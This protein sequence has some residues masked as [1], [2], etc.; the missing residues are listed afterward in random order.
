MHLICLTINVNYS[1]EYTKARYF[2]FR[3]TYI[4]FFPLSQ[5]FV[6]FTGESTQHGGIHVVDKVSGT[7]VV[8]DGV[9][10]ENR[11]IYD[12]VAYYSGNQRLYL[13]MSSPSSSLG[14]IQVLRNAFSWKFDTH[15]PP[16][17]AN[18]IEPYIFGMLFSGKSG[19]PHWVM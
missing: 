3:Q 5:D 12:V 2:H 10:H 17:N 11:T 15:P 1:Y 14:A 6:G 13:G 16:R 7:E 18:N 4:V 9:T 8:D 19:T